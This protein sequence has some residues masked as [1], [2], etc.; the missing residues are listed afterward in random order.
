MIY[1]Y[2]PLSA[3]DA[4]TFVDSFYSFVTVLSLIV[5]VADDAFVSFVY[6]CSKKKEDPSYD[7]QYRAREGHHVGSE[8]AHV[9]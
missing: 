5:I 4:L 3:S 7:S 9:W 6:K 8:D 1:I 2:V